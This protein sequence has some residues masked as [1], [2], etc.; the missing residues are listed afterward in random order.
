VIGSAIL[1]AAAA[2]LTAPASDDRTLTCS[3][4]LPAGSRFRF[5]G[6]FDKDGLHS[7]LSDLIK[8]EGEFTPAS[9]PGIV[10]T[11]DGTDTRLWRLGSVRSSQK[12]DAS[13]TRYGVQGAVL[14]I[15]RH[16]FV[17]RHWGRSL[18]GVGLCDVRNSQTGEKDS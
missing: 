14:L 10:I 7:N 9:P 12:F 13:L 5:E 8:V 1:L 2:G 16:K 3:L 18:V 4:E 11:S 17:G 6:H 15:E